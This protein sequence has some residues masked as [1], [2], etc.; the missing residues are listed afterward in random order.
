MQVQELS[1]TFESKK[2]LHFFLQLSALI[3]NGETRDGASN[4]TNSRLEIWH[5]ERAAKI[6]G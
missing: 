2:T 1:V 5:A 4:S 3:S 6:Y